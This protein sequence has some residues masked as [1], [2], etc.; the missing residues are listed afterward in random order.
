MGE[1]RLMSREGIPLMHNSGL[2]RAS[3][4]KWT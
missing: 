1:L 3:E 2:I 4:V